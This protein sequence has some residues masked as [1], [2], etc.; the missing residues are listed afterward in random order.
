MRFW[1]ACPA[2]ALC[3]VLA[4]GDLIGLIVTRL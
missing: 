3:G 4:L 2:A 1:F